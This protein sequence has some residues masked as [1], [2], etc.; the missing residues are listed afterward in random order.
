MVLDFELEFQKIEQFIGEKILKEKF[1][2]QPSMTTSN[3]SKKMFESKDKNYII[4]RWK[5][6][7]SYQ[8]LNKFQNILDLFKINIYNLKD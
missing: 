5:E 7:F 4:E 2:N 8:D 3:K 1:I 6:K